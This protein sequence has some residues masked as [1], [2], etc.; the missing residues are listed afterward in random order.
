MNALPAGWT[1]EYNNANG[2][3]Y[4]WNRAANTAQYEYPLGYDKCE[5]L[6]HMDFQDR[7]LCAEK[8][9]LFMYPWEDHNN[10]FCVNE[11]VC[12]RIWNWD[13]H[14]CSVRMRRIQS[15]QDAINELHDYSD[16]SL[17][18]VVLGGHGN[19]WTLHWGEGNTCGQ[20]HLCVGDWKSN[21]LLRLLSRKMLQH[22]T[23]FTD[24]CLSATTDSSK[25]RD[26]KNL[27]SWVASQVGK[28]IRVIGS[29]LSFGKVRVTRF[30]AWHATIDVAQENGVQRTSV[31]GGAT[32]PS[33]AVSSTP[34]SSGN[35][36]CPISRPTCKTTDG[37][38]CPMSSGKT[39]Y[40]Y[41][42]PMCAEE[43]AKVRC[44]C[45]R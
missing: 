39:S 18:H 16:N 24:S 37:N 13:K 1:S 2:R 35:C 38:A 12:H 28:G 6:K 33:F 4:F 29:V 22:G 15:I 30:K 26:G 34:D 14:A 44:T 23:I 21:E 20:S 25:H 17:K 27:A 19:G 40:K 31:A 10:A 7:P 5:R 45:Q 8:N 9:V 36:K 11:N 41:F 42:L 32:C 43:W 3:E